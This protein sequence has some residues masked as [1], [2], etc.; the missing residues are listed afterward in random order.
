[1]IT[2]TADNSQGDWTSGA[3]L[4]KRTAMVGGSPR[5]ATAMER[6]STMTNPASAAAVKVLD[7]AANVVG[8]NLVG[9]LGWHR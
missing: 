2:A 7:F 3:K 1:M 8:G 4:P 6:I 9:G 5:R